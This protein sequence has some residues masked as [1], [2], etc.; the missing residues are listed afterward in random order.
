M[1]NETIKAKIKKEKNEMSSK[2][3][4]TSNK[5]KSFD[6][7]NKLISRVKSNQE[8]ELERQKNRIKKYKSGIMLGRS[9]NDSKERSPSVNSISSDDSVLSD[10]PSKKKK[11]KRND[12]S[13]SDE[14]Y[15]RGKFL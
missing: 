5:L 12:A 2:D 13:A 10:K 7:R 6:L 14:E 3:K 4:P 15:V 11:K 9:L 8:Q 1:K